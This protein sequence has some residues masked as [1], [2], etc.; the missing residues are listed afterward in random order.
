M[1]PSAFLRLLAFTA[2]GVA[3]AVCLW[4]YSPDYGSEKEFGQK[5]FPDLF[6]RI[7]DAAVLRIGH[8]DRTLTFKRDPI[9][10]WRIA[11]YANY[12]ADKE[13]IRNTLL[14]LATLEKIEKK[15]AVADYYP[16]I[17]V[18]D[19]GPAAGSHLVTLSDAA[20]AQIMSLLVGKTTSGF[21]WDG[22]GHFVRL[23]GD[24]Q[25]WLTRASLDV[26]GD[27][28]A[29]TDTRLLPRITQDRLSFVSVMAQNGNR[30][31]S[32]VRTDPGDPLQPVAV[33][34]PY[35]LAD[36]TRSK[37]MA[38]SFATQE[39]VNVRSKPE[40][41]EKT[42]PYLVVMLITQDGLQVFEFVYIFDGRPY[43]YIN[44]KAIKDAGERARDEA[45]KI[46]LRHSPWLYQVSPDSVLRLAPFM[47]LPEKK[48]GGEKAAEKPKTADA[49]ATASEPEKAPAPAEQPK[50]AEKKPEKKTAKAAEKKSKPATV[51]KP[52]AKTVKAKKT[53]QAQKQ[54][55][56]TEAKQ[57]QKAEAKPAQGN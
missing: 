17:G 50:T 41:L 21:Q 45:E 7:N 9:G 4:V 57:P 27:F 6:D 28:A 40:D 49:T 54:P 1:K 18:E 55:K 2:V 42:K 23:P 52:A 22:Q 43:V 56:K 8:G 38:A 32:F 53:G 33:S 46:D 34:D 31:V 12:P 29:W 47:P 14:G 13:R 26:T 48:N 51:K 11:E 16:D 15:T 3:L 25:A 30:S 10:N 35:I 5:L 19:P 39:F 37:E 24:P 36:A 44:A 20:G